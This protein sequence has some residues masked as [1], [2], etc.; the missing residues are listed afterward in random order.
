MGLIDVTL[1]NYRG[2]AASIPLLIDHA[3]RL[4]TLAILDSKRGSFHLVK[5]LLLLEL[6][7]LQ[8]L[9]I[10]GGN[11]DKDKAYAKLKPPMGRW[12]SIR[13]LRLTHLVLP[14]KS[15]IFSSLR[16]LDLAHLQGTPKMCTLPL[17]F[18]LT[19]LE[20]CHGLQELKL[21]GVVP[22][23]VGPSEIIVPL[24]QL[25]RLEVISEV[26]LSARLPF[27]TSPLVSTMIL[28]HVQ[29]PLHASL[30]FVSKVKASTPVGYRSFIPHEDP[31]YI[32]I[33]AH[34]T[35]AHLLPNSFACS[36]PGGGTLEV[37][38]EFDEENEEPWF[39][40]D[41][42]LRD[43]SFLLARAPITHLSLVSA[44]L[45]SASMVTAFGT[46]PGL[47]TLEFSTIPMNDGEPEDWRFPA[48]FSSIILP[49]EAHVGGARAPSDE[50]DS[51]E[52]ST[53]RPLPLRSLRVLRFNALLWES[54]V[55]GLVFASLY[56]RFAL[57]AP[58]LSE[59]YVA[60]YGRS[61]GGID[62]TEKQEREMEMLGTLVDGPV[63]YEDCEPRPVFLSPDNSRQ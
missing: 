43:V 10:A 2:Y 41:R 31:S 56:A 26:G 38:V 16:V 17:D 52:G 55:L 20:S 24:P 36:E 12:P 61:A 6:P 58:N 42:Q 14:V 3:D 35:F 29:L 47:T 18:A 60:M 21:N 51:E 23:L 44:R 19:A 30:K 11:Y 32:P 5:R 27:P 8:E 15:A 39:H 1:R 53:A 13:V 63:V 49:R 46:F 40:Q 28:R 34:A 57:G 48:L 9:R 37:A 45:H 25:R 59:L 50:S 62:D 22:E 33:L 54:R 4:R 7:N